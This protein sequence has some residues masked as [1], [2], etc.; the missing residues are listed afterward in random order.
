MEAASQTSEISGIFEQHTVGTSLRLLLNGCPTVD[1]AVLKGGR[2]LIAEGVSLVTQ[3]VLRKGDTIYMNDGIYGSF[4]EQRF[5]SFD[6]DYPP[7]GIALDTKGKAKILSGENRPFR[8]YGPTCD[9]ADA[10]KYAT[11]LFTPVVFPGVLI[12]CALWIGRSAPR[13]KM[14]PRSTKKPSARCPSP[15]AISPGRMC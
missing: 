9:S 13:S 12:R 11:A 10:A 15:A 4:D 2:A 14:L 1:L 3:V 7:S 8:A 5:A 6:E